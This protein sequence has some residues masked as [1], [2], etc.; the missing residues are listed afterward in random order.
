MSHIC[1]LRGL[2]ADR[3]RLTALSVSGTGTDAGAQV[4]PF[5]TAANE[6]TAEA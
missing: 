6:G 5:G 4:E 2:C 1:Q 3:R